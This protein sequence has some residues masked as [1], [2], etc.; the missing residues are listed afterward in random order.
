M[1]TA[2]ALRVYYVHAAKGCGGAD[3]TS[4]RQVEQA[5]I[6]GDH[7][8]ERRLHISLNEVYERLEEIDSDNAAPQGQAWPPCYPGSLAAVTPLGAG[9]A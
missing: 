9:R 6:D 5:L 4:M 8:T 7:E 1:C 3:A 2:C